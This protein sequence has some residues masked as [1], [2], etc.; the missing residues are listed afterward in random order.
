VA[1]RHDEHLDVHLLRDHVEG[2]ARPE[3]VGRLPENVSVG[4]AGDGWLEA[5]N[6]LS[7]ISVR[8]REGRIRG[9]SGPVA[10]RTDPSLVTQPI[11][12]SAG[13]ADL[14]ALGFRRVN[15]S[16]FCVNSRAYYPACG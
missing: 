1:S 9:L 10:D 13:S 2:L 4:F 3:C 16:S 8:A 7:M 6:G 5:S 11:R 14:P 15:T 12:F